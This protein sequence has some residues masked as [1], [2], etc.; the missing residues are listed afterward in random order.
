MQIARAVGFDRRRR[1]RSPFV[2]R[3]RNRQAAE[4][5]ADLLH[6]LDQRIEVLGV[7]PRHVDRER[8]EA[9]QVMRRAGREEGVRD[10]LVRGPL[11][12]ALDHEKRRGGGR[13]LA[14][15]GHEPG[16]FGGI[17]DEHHG[18]RI[19]GGRPGVPR[20]RPVGAVEGVGHAVA[21][22]GALP[23]DERLRIREAGERAGGDLE[24]AV[25]RLLVQH[26]RV[27]RHDGRDPGA[28]HVGAERRA[29]ERQRLVGAPL[30]QQV[31]AAPPLAGGHVAERH[32]RDGRREHRDDE[33]H[34][35]READGAVGHAPPA[36]RQPPSDAP[37]GLGDWTPGP[38]HAAVHRPA[39]ADA[40]R[41]RI[42]G[43]SRA[44]DSTGRRRR[45]AG[46]AWPAPVRDR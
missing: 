3:H 38:G 39:E 30:E 31:R 9:E 2:V 1:D 6:L 40:V 15:G 34:D 46:S 45:G 44:R 23:Q 18:K 10:H 12:R 26:R 43:G 5:A 13:L 37:E 19:V 41:S 28:L 33:R 32:Q 25:G 22:C 14:H 17:A 42:I 11:D 35:G 16:Q 29:N 4:A 24:E 27:E 7:H 20:R 36:E 21:P 8:H